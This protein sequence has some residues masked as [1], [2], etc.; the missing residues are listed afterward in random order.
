MEKVSIYSPVPVPRCSKVATQGDNSL[1]PPDAMPGGSR[2]RSHTI[3][4]GKK[5]RH[6]RSMSSGYI[7][8][9]LSLKPWL[10]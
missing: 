7:S 1:T 9:K 2:E 10:E 8:T 4:S 3:V 5:V 6:V